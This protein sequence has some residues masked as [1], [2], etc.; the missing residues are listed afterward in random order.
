LKVWHDLGEHANPDETEIATLRQCA[1]PFVKT[2]RTANRIE[3][4][5]KEN[6]VCYF[7]I[8]TEKIKSDR[9]YTY[10]RLS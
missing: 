6:A 9:G 7:E 5:L 4:E 3:L 2:C 8:K 10:G 1:K